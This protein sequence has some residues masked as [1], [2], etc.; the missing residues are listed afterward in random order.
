MDRRRWLLP[1]LLIALCGTGLAQTEKPSAA[2]RSTLPSQPAPQAATP[3]TE[4]IPQT[5]SDL[6]ETP[7]AART[8]R[9]SHRRGEENVILP[10]GTAI[11]FKLDEA[12]S[13]KHNQRG[14]V[15]LA[16]V[17]RDVVVNGRTLV[18]AGLEPA[19]LG[20]PDNQSPAYSWAP[21]GKP[22]P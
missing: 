22:A 4:E 12:I 11:Y 9:L 13:S 1:L 7:P 15:F 14:D 18:P 20:E 6:Q 5:D 16:H 3:S 17:T 19:R 8:P 10:E 2:Q 21:T